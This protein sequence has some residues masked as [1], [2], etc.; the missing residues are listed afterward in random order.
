MCF[1]PCR[2][3]K[4][5]DGSRGSD[6]GSTAGIHVSPLVKRPSRIKSLPHLLSLLS[7]PGFPSATELNIHVIRPRLRGA[8]H[9]RPGT[10]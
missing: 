2:E 5:Q 6:D 4:R 9:V 7:V 3:I 8:G 10:Y 1:W